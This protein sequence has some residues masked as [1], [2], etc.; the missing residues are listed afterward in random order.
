M[1]ST[2]LWW[3]YLVTWKII[4][5]SKFIWS[6]KEILNL[7]V[8][9]SFTRSFSVL[10]IWASW[11][12]HEAG[13]GG[14]NALTPTW[15]TTS[16]RRRRGAKSQAHKIPLLPLVRRPHAGLL[17]PAQRWGWGALVSP[18]SGTLSHPHLTSQEINSHR[19]E[20]GWQLTADRGMRVVHPQ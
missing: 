9:I 8:L 7:Y 16:R 5:L 6:F 19:L 12:A 15:V 1:Q 10:F 2:I 13:Y 17:T 11:S 4:H 3:M 18:T 14:R 20:T